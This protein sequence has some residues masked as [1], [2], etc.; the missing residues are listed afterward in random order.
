MNKINELVDKSKM[1]KELFD[2]FTHISELKINEALNKTI[3]VTINEIITFIA[4]IETP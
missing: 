4:S 2:K 1:P 3:E